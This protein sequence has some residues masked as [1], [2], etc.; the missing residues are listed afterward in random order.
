VQLARQGRRA[1]KERER[2]EIDPLVQEMLLSDPEFVAW[3][4]PQDDEVEDDE[5]AAAA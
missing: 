3:L 1:V 4:V 2:V 5:R